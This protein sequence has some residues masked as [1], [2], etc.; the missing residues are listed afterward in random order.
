MVERR[1][2]SMRFGGLY[3]GVG[4]TPI[5]RKDLLEDASG[6][7]CDWLVSPYRSFDFAQEIINILACTC[8]IFA[9]DREQVR[10]LLL[11]LTF[12]VP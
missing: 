8:A 4:C 7:S 9:H 6:F 1:Q 3:R 12:G 10:S 2:D 5:I 11:L